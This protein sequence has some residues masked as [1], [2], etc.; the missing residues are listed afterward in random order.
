MST[1]KGSHWISLKKALIAGTIV[2]VCLFLWGVYSNQSGTVADVTVATA[3]V[4]RGDLIVDVL[5]ASSIDAAESQIIRSKVEGKATLIFIIPEGSTIT[6]EDVEN[7]K[8][9]VQMDSADLRD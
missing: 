4:T 7:K 1:N 9:L 5:E 8:V 3:P 6:H 2:V